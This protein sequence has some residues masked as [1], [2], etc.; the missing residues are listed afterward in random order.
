MLEFVY[1]CEK[2]SNANQSR[3]NTPER[4]TIHLKQMID[5]NE[6]K[7]YI[8]ICMYHYYLISRCFKQKKYI[9]RLYYI[10]SD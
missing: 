4:N 2:K 9:D 1:D 7:N 8:R 3:K 10:K 5:F 6:Y